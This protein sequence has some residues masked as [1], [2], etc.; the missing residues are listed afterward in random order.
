MTSPAGIGL[1]LVSQGGL[2]RELVEA[3]AAIL[4]EKPSGVL[5]A[6]ATNGDTRAAIES[7]VRDAVDQLAKERGRVL[8]LCDLFG[9]TPANVARAVSRENPAVACCC[10]LNLAM[11]LEALNFRHLPLEQAVPKV[12]AAG[13]RAVVNGRDD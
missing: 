2:A 7:G 12:L 8:I 9:A 1:L 3:A 6:Q 10:G 4:G 13:R 11:L 5:V